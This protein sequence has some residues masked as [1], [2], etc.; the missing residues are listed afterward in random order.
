MKWKARGPL[1]RAS[2][3]SWKEVEGKGNKTKC[4]WQLRE[5]MLGSVAL[6][7]M[8]SNVVGHVQY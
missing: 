2:S 5:E 8:D 4:E 1:E 7:S 3:P 6:R